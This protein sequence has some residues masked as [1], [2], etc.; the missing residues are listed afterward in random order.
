MFVTRWRWAAAIA[1][2]LPRF[3][4]GRKVPPQIARM[5][6]EDLLAAAFPDQVACAENLSG[7]IQIPAHPL[8]TQAIADCLHEAMDATTWLALLQRIEVGTLA[9]VARD[10]A[11]PSPLAL[12][13]L[14]ARPHAFLDDAPLEERRTQAVLSRRWLDPAAAADIGRL[15]PLAVA[16]VRAEAWPDARSVDEL[17][18]ALSWMGYLTGAEIAANPAWPALIA[19]LAGQSRAVLL[20]TDGAADP[21]ALWLAVERQGQ[22]AARSADEEALASILHGRLEGLGPVTAAALAATLPGVTLAQV[23]AALVRLQTQGVV[24]RGRFS[25]AGDAEEWCERRLLARIHRYTVKTLR[26]QIE[27]VAVRDFM[28][29]A[30]DWQ[31]LTPATRMQGPDALLA[32]LDQLEGTEVAAGG[33]ESEVLPARIQ[34]YE[35]AWL[36]EH[37]LAGRYAWTR[38]GAQQAV[39]PV[40]ATPICL[41]ARRNLKLWS[42]LG[43]ELPE[44]QLGS[45]AA[46]VAA[47]LTAHGASFFDELVDHTGLL[48]VQVEAAL[49]ELVALGLANSDSFTGLRALLQ[50]ADRRR[51]GTVRGRRRV[52]LF[53]MA[54]SG[55]WSWVRRLPAAREA[56]VEHVVRTL[57]KR[58]GVLCW[59]LLRVEADWLPPWRELAVCLRRLEARGEIRGGRFVAG[60]SGEQFALPEAVGALR[61][62]RRK[63]VGDEDVSL[64]AVDPLNL[65]GVLTA[66]PRLPALTSNRVLYRGGLPVAMLVAG[67]VRF[68]A[69]LDEARRWQAQNALVRRMPACAPVVEEPP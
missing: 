56:V 29:F 60:L 3:R 43:P 62:I 37:C 58:W 30:F 63:P 28:R 46:A 66:G 34:G 64:S 40:R 42:G 25:G 61:A 55:R 10:L 52:A 35:P 21:A 4:G 69:E 53:G 38:I 18:D 68:L 6:A 33:W 57:L 27:P 7:E 20:H 17:H 41:L 31:H 50:P 39:A 24:M 32:V 13:V 48:P 5:N 8:V 59:Q 16:R 54:D 65:T 15:D 12:E 51:A 1:L 36:D 22:F 9:V 14:A 49:A 11:E 19:Q 44:P 45:G 23:Q 2:A 26:E 67:E 47:V